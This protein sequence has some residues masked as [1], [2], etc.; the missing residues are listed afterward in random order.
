MRWNRVRCLV[1]CNRRCLSAIYSFVLAVPPKSG[2][3]RAAPTETSP[4][5]CYALPVRLAKK[6]PEGRAGEL[7]YES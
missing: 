4:T 3:C 5:V 2:G 6:L 1:L 7:L